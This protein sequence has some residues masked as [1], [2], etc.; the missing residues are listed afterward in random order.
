MGQSR[1]G[2]D[3]TGL[4]VQSV[5]LLKLDAEFVGQQAATTVN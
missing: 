3:F 5:G 1:H 2:R 4:W